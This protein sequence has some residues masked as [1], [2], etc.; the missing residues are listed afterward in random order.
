MVATRGAFPKPN[1]GAPRTS[2]AWRLDRTMGAPPLARYADEWHHRSCRRDTIA[3]LRAPSPRPQLR[4]G[5]CASTWSQPSQGDRSCGRGSDAE[6]L[7]KRRDRAQ[8]DVW[9]CLIAFGRGCADRPAYVRT[10]VRADISAHCNT[11]R[12]CKRRAD[13][14]STCRDRDL[15][16]RVECWTPNVDVGWSGELLDH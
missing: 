11:E 13:R 4:E 9:A 16:Q 5:F 14:E 10:D 8:L 2:G 1:T 7:H 3:D 6:R 12:R 15:C